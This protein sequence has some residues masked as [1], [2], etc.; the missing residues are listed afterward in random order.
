MDEMCRHENLEEEAATLVQ[1]QGVYG[2]AICI[3]CKRRFPLIFH[4]GQWVEVRAPIKIAGSYSYNH[5]VDCRCEDCV[6]YGD[7]AW[8]G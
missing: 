5:R 1:R 4:K 8:V 3:E 7:I 6:R 2:N